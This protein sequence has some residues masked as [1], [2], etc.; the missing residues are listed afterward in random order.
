MRLYDNVELIGK[1]IFIMLMYRLSLNILALQ[2]WTGDLKLSFYEDT[3]QTL[4]RLH[5]GL[6]RTLFP[7]RQPCRLPKRKFQGYTLRFFDPFLAK[8]LD[9]FSP[10]RDSLRAQVASARTSF[11]RWRTE[12]RSLGR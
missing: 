5:S 7:F 10:K 3:F 12:T 8:G 6:R 1:V 11:R 9:P 4:R 2:V